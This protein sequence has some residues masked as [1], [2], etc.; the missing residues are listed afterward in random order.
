MLLWPRKSSESRRGQ[1]AGGKIDRANFCHAPALHARLQPAKWVLVGFGIVFIVAGATLGLA[2]V[3]VAQ[4][5]L[6]YTVAQL[7]RQRQELR[8]A[9]RLLRLEL[10]VRKRP[11]RLYPLLR[12]QLRLLPPRLD[13]VRSL[14]GCDAKSLR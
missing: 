12:D 6:G 13:Q 1:G 7:Q 11:R 8:D 5:R 4:L 3:R 10:A 2:W 14:R 9:E